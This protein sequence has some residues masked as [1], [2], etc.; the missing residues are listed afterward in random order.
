MAALPSLDTDAFVDSKLHCCR[1]RRH[2]VSCKRLLSIAKPGLLLWPSRQVVTLIKDHFSKL[3]EAEGRE[4]KL[5]NLLLE[6]LFKAGGVVTSSK[7][8][9]LRKNA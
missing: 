8:K 5:V 1:V 4:V 7:V 2:E 9:L 3:S 6:L